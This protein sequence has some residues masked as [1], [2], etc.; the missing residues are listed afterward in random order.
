M[1]AIAK[2]ALLLAALLAAAAASADPAPDAADAANDPLNAVVKLEVARA[3]PNVYRPWITLTATGAGSGV[4][5]AP[6]RILTCAHCVTDASYIRVRKHNEDALYHAAVEHLDHDADLALVRV[7]SPDF[8]ADV[9]PMEIGGTPRIQDEVLAIGYPIGGT[10]ISFTRGIVSRIEDIV[11]LHGQTCLLGVQV[12]A[13]INPGNS[14]GPVL[15]LGT[16]LVAGIAFQGDKKGEALG[17][18]IPAEIIRHFL[19][20]AEDGK[21]DGFP[22]RIFEEN[23]MESPAKRRYYGM[24]DGWTGVVVED[25]ATEEGK[26][27][28]K[29]DDV[30]LRLDGYPVSNNGKIRLAGNEPRSLY[31]PVYLKQVGEEI[32]VA[33][34]RGGE[35]VETS[36]PAVKRD[37]RIRTRAGG[38]KPDWF[39]FGGIVFTTASAEFLSAS[40]AEFHDDI[41]ADKAFEGD[42]AVV[43]SDILPDV[44]VEGYLGCDDTLVR[45]VNGTPVRNLRHLVE[46]V[47]GCEEGFLRFGLDDGEEW[48]V[49]MVV[50]AGE[51]R[52]ATPRVMKRYQIPA[53]RSED[54][55]RAPRKRGGGKAAREK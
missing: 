49:D 36:F 2:R 51:L 21:I 43:V 5:I 48:D 20:D 35:A 37:L 7:D 19:V 12:D 13:A 34:L 11:Y 9:T 25:V 16:G 15:D 32:P 44:C 22:D 38:G 14:G 45:S 3:T 31:Y 50:D 29:A 47:D 24:E 46:L 26:K 1:E 40:K 28:L 4:V 54:L 18:M 8:M 39:L 6:G 10:D 30:I 41:L 52:E 17:Y 23:P 27:A 53:D 42:E 55:R 33:V